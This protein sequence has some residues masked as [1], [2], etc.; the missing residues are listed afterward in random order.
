MQ[1]FNAQNC[2]PCISYRGLRNE[3]VSPS[4]GNSPEY[5]YLIKSSEGLV[6]LKG[7]L[8]AKGFAVRRPAPL[9]VRCWARHCQYLP[10]AGG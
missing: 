9:G 5:F 7:R 4:E 8:S 6:T 2:R 1:A 3:T 10:S